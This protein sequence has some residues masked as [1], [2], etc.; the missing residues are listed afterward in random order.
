MRA[1][2]R[3]TEVIAMTDTRDQVHE[4]ERQVAPPVRS[5]E[6]SDLI[7]RLE[8]ATA[9]DTD[10]NEKIAFAVQWRP[11]DQPSKRSFDEHEARHDYAT[12]WIAHAPFRLAWP[13]PN[14]TASIDAAL[15]LVPEG[16]EIEIH[17]LYGVAVAKVGLNF[18]DGPEFGE[19]L[20]GLLPI[21]LCIAALRARAATAMTA[22]A[23]EQSPLPRETISKATGAAS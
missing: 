18:H 7:A 6:I 10:L 3:K 16:A 2:S 9:P 11:Q 14:Y 13:I 12:A 17:N 23:E 15:T 20:G 8:N 5:G 4:R 22:Q 21:A 1:T 19:H